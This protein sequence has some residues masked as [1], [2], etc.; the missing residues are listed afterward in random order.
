MSSYYTG[1]GSRTTPASVLEH[2]QSIAA[3]LTRKEYI[4]RSGGAAG[5]DTAFERGC[6]SVNSQ[7]KQI[8]LP[9]KN[10]N[11]NK[12]PLFDIPRG[13]FTIASE[14]HPAWSSLSHPVR[15]LHA[16]NVLQVLGMDLQT[17]TAFVICWTPSGQEIGGTRTAIKLAHEHA[18]RVVNLALEEF[19]EI[20]Q[21][22]S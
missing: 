3:D 9:W 8:Y 16:R 5:A 13:A 7:A 20:I 10:F 19:H 4:L 6:D 1:I 21:Q 17:P 14:I 18:I 2:M 12:S 11:N 15:R 22:D